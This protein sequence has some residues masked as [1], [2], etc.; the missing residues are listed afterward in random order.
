MLPKISSAMLIVTHACNL[1]CRYCFVQQ[2]PSKMT[3]ETALKAAQFLIDNSDEKNIPSI[4]FFGGEPMIMWDDIVHPLIKWIREEYKNPFTI[5][6]TTNGTLLNEERIEFLKENNVH[7][8]LSVDGAKET[9]DYN[10]PQHNGCGSFDL[11]EKNIKPLLSFNKDMTLRMTAIPATCNHIFE[12]IMWGNSMGYN[13]AF[14]IANVFEAWDKEHWEILSKEIE[15]YSDY[16]IEQCRNN[17][18][19]IMLNPIKDAFKDIKKINNACSVCEHRYSFGCKAAGKCGLGSGK[20]AS[21]HPNGNIYGCQE[22]TSNEGDKSIFY[23][24]NL[25][26]GVDDNLRINLMNLYNENKVHGDDCENCQYDDICDGGCVANNYLANQDINY[27]PDVFCKWRRLI[28]DNAVFI[29]QTLGNEENELFKKIW[30][31]V[32]L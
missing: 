28:L 31:G 3:F 9:Q 16:F 18:I 29:M 23:I 21:I 20:F 22:M 15:K 30:E 4:N 25:D 6:M 2:E 7:I 17:K 26:D 12:N 5:S 13:S 32:K 14:I 27:V 11:V 8:L 1:A 24:G 10:R 19:P